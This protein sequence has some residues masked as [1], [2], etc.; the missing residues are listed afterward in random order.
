MKFKLHKF[1]TD[2]G[3][4][5]AQVAEAIGI[6]QGLYNQLESGKR[7]MNETY[8]VS[9]AELYGIAPIQLIEDDVRDDPLFAELDL[10]FRSLSP[11]E[12]QIVVDSAKGIAAARDRKPEGQR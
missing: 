2:K 7:R 10:A 5:Q 3:L 9:L 6:S 4:T 8:L 12:R 11:I 1:R